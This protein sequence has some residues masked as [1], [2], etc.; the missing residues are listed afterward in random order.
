MR[1]NIMQ[2]QKT[3]FALLLFLVSPLVKAQDYAVEELSAEET[4]AI[5]PFSIAQVVPT[6]S[7]LRLFLSTDNPAAIADLLAT[8]ALQ[9]QLSDNVAGTE[10]PVP[11]SFGEAVWCTADGDPVYLAYQDPLPTCGG[12]PPSMIEYFF[13]VAAVLGP[14]RDLALGED[15]DFLWLIEEE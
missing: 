13:D 2:F 14:G 4:T 6:D 15:P 1:R 12:Q 8:W 5:R 10:T 11:I 7:G 3:L 9:T